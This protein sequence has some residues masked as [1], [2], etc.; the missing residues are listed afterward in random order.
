MLETTTSLEYDGQA[1]PRRTRTDY[2]YDGFGNLTATLAHGE[3]DASGNDPPPPAADDNRSTVL[4][5]APA[6]VGLYLVNLLSR[7]TLRV[8]SPSSSEIARETRFFYDGDTTGTSVPTV[9]N[10]TRRVEVLAQAGKPDPTTR[11]TYDAFGNVRTVVD[12]RE[13]AGELSAGEG[14]TTYAYDSTFHSFLTSVENSNGH[15]TEYQYSGS[16]CTALPPL[17]NFPPG[18][19]LVQAELRPNDIGIGNGWLRCYDAFGRIGLERAPGALTESTWGYVDTPGQVSITRSDLTETGARATMTELDGLGRVMRTT[20]PGSLGRNVLQVRVYDASGRLNSETAP[21]F[22]GDPEVWTTIEYDALDRVKRTDLPGNRARTAQYDRGLVTLTT[23]ANPAIPSDPGNRITERHIDAFGNADWV[24]ENAGVVNYTTR[25]EYDVSGALTSVEDHLGNVTTIV[26]DR[27]GQKTTLVDPDTGATSYTYDANGN[28]LTRIDG[29]GT[30]TWTYDQLNRP[31]ARAAPGAQNASW[32]YDTAGN[33]KG[34]LR[35]R[36]DAAGVYTALGYDRLGRPTSESQAVDGKVFAFGSSFSRLGAISTRQYPTG[37]TLQ[38]VYDARGFA[39]EVRDQGGSAYATG[40]EWDARGRLVRWMASSGVRSET[41]YDATTGRL[42][43]L[44]VGLDL[45]SPTLQHLSYQPNALDLV[46]GITDQLD[47]ARSQT[48]AYDKLAR[49]E[50]ATGPYG[51][52]HYDYSA[53][54]NLLCKDA[55][56]PA[57]SDPSCTSGKKLV[58]PNAGS[59]RPHAPLT[60]DGL[61]A[62]YGSTGNL[63][64][65]GG[66]V[67]TYTAFGELATATQ[68]GTALADLTYDASGR[69]SKIVDRTQSPAVVRYLVAGDFEWDATHKLGKIHVSLGGSLIATRLERYTAQ[70]GAPPSTPLGP[71]T[72]RGIVLLPAGVAG[73]LLG[74]QL[75]YLRRRN[76]PLA[77]PALAGSTAIVLYLGLVTPVLAQIPDGDMNQDDRLDAADALLMTRIVDGSVPETSADQA[78]GDIAPLELAP[79]T[80]SDVNAGDLVLLLRGIDGQDVDGDGVPADVELAEGASPFREDSDRDGVPDNVEIL[81]LGS[82]PAQTDTDQDGFGDA[83]DPEPVQGVVFWYGDH[84]G[85]TTVRTRS[86]GVLLERVVYRPYGEAIAVAGGAASPPEFGYTG[87]RFEQ[88][89]GIYDYGA[90]WYDP[91]LGRFLQPDS[92]VPSPTNPQSLNR[93]AYVLN[94]PISRIDPSGNFSLDAVWGGVTSVASS[95]FSPIGNF[96]SGFGSSLGHSFGGGSQPSGSGWAYGAGASLGGSVG[97]LAGLGVSALSLPFHGA[98]DVLGALPFVGGGLAAPFNWAGDRLYGAGEGIAL[99]GDSFS[100]TNW[101]PLSP[102]TT[103]VGATGFGAVGNVAGITQAVGNT[104][105]AVLS[106]SLGE[107][108]S[109]AGAWFTGIVPRHGLASGPGHPRSSASRIGS[110][111]TGPD[112]NARPHDEAYAEKRNQSSADRALVDALDFRTAPIPGPV[113]GIYQIGMYGAFSAKLAC[114]PSCDLP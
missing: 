29:L 5:Y 30:T 90:R 14:T 102:F 62:G 95:V 12:P 33:G 19:G 51:V 28:L 59:A 39:T 112:I 77:R 20:T 1:T 37:R 107:F 16:A 47:P 101:T 113:T 69:R 48:F 3:V 56:Q 83:S 87:Q 60:V 27:L 82:D 96:A 74:L 52:L 32:T 61:A 93:Y 53:I 2:Q 57:S 10:L 97:I 17:I 80:P 40:A 103:D 6:N 11:F 41:N 105:D 86:D 92:I 38:W 94:N 99:R 85:S 98:G 79:E 114:G 9:G 55:T 64:S 71:G 7:S 49:L 24:R 78:R 50:Q 65:L 26:T 76:V 23:L 75:L 109:L 18:A 104:L 91:V 58:Y 46:T 43:S 15:R 111:N 84:L 8:G 67:Y 81:T 106:P 31:V 66:R 110:F 73:L 35:Q 72:A 42:Q 88:G 100:R 34:L 89:L 13:H 63:Q 68:S 22:T 44:K 45:T 25:Y 36:T 21:R 108:A 70:A 4:E 54:G